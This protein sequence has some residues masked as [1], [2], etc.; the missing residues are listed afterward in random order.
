MVTPKNWDINMKERKIT[1]QDHPL[2]PE[3]KAELISQGFRVLDSKFAPVE[4]EKPKV[5]RKKKD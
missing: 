3:R 2:S 4:Q 5:K 1:Y